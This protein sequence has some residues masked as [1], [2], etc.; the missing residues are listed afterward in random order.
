MGDRESDS[1]RVNYAR[2]AT[3]SE[4]AASVVQEGRSSERI[5]IG[6]FLLWVVVLAITLLRVRDTGEMTGRQGALAA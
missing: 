2:R 3:V 5:N 1:S 4:A 6:V